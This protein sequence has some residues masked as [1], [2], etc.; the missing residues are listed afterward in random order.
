M[1]TATPTTAIP[2]AT[3]TGA[4]TPPSTAPSSTS[5]NPPS[6]TTCPTP[7]AQEPPLLNTAPTETSLPS[8]PSNKQEPGQ[9]N[10]LPM[11]QVAYYLAHAIINIRR[12]GS[13]RYHCAAALGV[14]ASLSIP[15]PLPFSFCLRTPPNW[16]SM[17]LVASVKVR[18]ESQEPWSEDWIQIL[19]RPGTPLAFLLYTAL[20]LIFSSIYIQEASSGNKDM[21]PLDHYFGA[22]MLSGLCAGLASLGIMLLNGTLNSKWVSDDDALERKKARRLT[23]RYWMRES[24]VTALVYFVWTCVSQPEY[25]GPFGHNYTSP[26]T[27][28]NQYTDKDTAVDLAAL[29]WEI[30]LRI[31]VLSAAFY[32]PL[33]PLV[34]I[35]ERIQHHAKAMA[36][37]GV[38]SKSTPGGQSIR[39]LRF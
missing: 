34:N 25:Y 14:H 32:V 10:V 27:L 33:E 29:E 37:N 7:A 11:G 24:L 28:Y 4:S 5:S 39:Y 30:F 22:I 6:L 17:P 12:G 9:Q 15:D 3:S 35:E 19:I 2:T 18:E 31:M 13:F 16:T 23:A 26:I 38:G 20:V 8:A 36:E 1:S 21:T